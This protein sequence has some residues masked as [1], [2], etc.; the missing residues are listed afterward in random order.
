MSRSVDCLIAVGF[1]M[2]AGAASAQTLPTPA[3]WDSVPAFAMK[4]GLDAYWNVYDSTTGDHASA[5]HARGFKSVVI[6][7]TFADYPGNQKEN[8]DQYIGTRGSNPWKMPA[9]FE[10]I[11]RRNIAA[12]TPPPAGGIYVHDI[13][14]SFET[15]SEAAWAVPASRVASGAKSLA[16]FDAVYYREWARW[17][18]QPVEWTK[19]QYPTARV[20]I[21]GP[22]PFYTETWN[23]GQMTPERIAF[24][25]QRDLKLWRPLDPF[26]DFIAVQAYLPNADAGAVYFIALHL[27]ANYERAQALSGKPI[28]AYDWLRYYHTDWTKAD[29]PVDPHLVEAMAMVPYFS[30]ARAVVLWGHEP[31]VKPG[32]GLPYPDL[33][34][35][36]RSLARIAELSEQ[37]GRGT[38]VIDESAHRLWQAKRPLVRRIEGADGECVILALNHW[39]RDSDTTTVDVP[40]GMKRVPIVIN[41]RHSTLAHVK[42]DGVTYH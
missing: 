35:F 27:E 10:R 13:E 2:L 28:F 14:F 12:T 3:G 4:G 20:G 11:V 41:G 16:D 38:L 26:V 21:F 5:A 33:P 18:I 24:Y 29:K 6:Q 8:I 39:Q 40:C 9:F 34:L 23:I 1:A 32:D 15:K 42:G 37:I 25:H 31:Q 19:Q 36:V 22:Q 30:G 7:N 17:F